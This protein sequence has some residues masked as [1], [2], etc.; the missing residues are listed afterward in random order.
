MTARPALLLAAL[1]LSSCVTPTPPAFERPD[2]PVLP[3]ALDEDFSFRKTIRFLN[4]PELMVET[5]N[6]PIMFERR[7]VNF[8]A[9]TNEERRRR[10]GSYFDFFWRAN[11]PADITVRFEYRQAKLGNAVRAKETTVSQARGTMKSSFAVIGD[12]FLW[13]GPVTAWRCLLIED[14]RIVAFTQS[15]LW[16]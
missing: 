10:L 4:Q 13:D 1:L 6:E 8:G 7:R 15:Y 16:K 3:L 5:R 11:R 12:E 2:A 14:K 9:L